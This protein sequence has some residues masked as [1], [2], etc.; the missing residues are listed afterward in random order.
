MSDNLDRRLALDTALTTRQA[1][2]SHR[3]P[4]WFSVTAALLTSAGLALLGASD[5][6]GHGSGRAIL[7]AS[8]LTLLLI[9]IALFAGLSFHW[10]RNGVI[11]DPAQGATVR[12]R[13]KWLW[14]TLAAV[15]GYATIWAVTG[16]TGWA[17][18]Y[19]G[20]ALGATAGYG[21][22]ARRNR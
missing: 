11:P 20:V 22:L 21:R 5:L 4:T 6:V 7:G 17:L 9:Q 8:G 3:V 13:W 2:S 14:L 12:Q 19:A 16:R 18:V 1:A 15:A 10:R